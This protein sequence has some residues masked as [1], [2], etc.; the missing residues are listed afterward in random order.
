[1][2][3]RDAFEANGVGFFGGDFAA[4][5]DIPQLVGTELAPVNETL[6]LND[7]EI[8]NIDQSVSAEILAARSSIVSFSNV[9]VSAADEYVPQY[10]CRE[11]MYEASRE[12]SRLVSNPCATTKMP[13]SPPNEQ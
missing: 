7:D 2:L 13:A 12:S 6:T 3:A 9:R 5:L 11:Q 10:K 1:M 8:N 4:C